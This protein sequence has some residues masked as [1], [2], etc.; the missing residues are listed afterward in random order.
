MILAEGRDETIA[1]MT[2]HTCMDCGHET[3]YSYG[4]NCMVCGLKTRHSYGDWPDR[5]PRAAVAFAAPSRMVALSERHPTA[6]LAA[7]V[8]GAIMGIA[9]VAIYPLVFVPV[10]VMLGV[11]LVA[12]MRYE[13]AQDPSE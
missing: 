11:A 8:P 9:A 3:R 4:R 10:M 5:H 2:I 7:A 1:R 12:S 6:T 13:E